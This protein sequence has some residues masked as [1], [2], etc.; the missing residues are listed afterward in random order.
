MQIFCIGLKK[1]IFV[2]MYIG[3]L[4]VLI[5]MQAKVYKMLTFVS[6]VLITNIKGETIVKDRIELQIENNFV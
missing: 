5:G 2:V 1:Y 6:G 3:M 4:F